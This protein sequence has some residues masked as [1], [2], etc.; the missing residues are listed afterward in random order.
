MAENITDDKA[1]KASIFI[2]KEAFR[3]ILTHVLRFGNDALKK[4]KEVMGVCLGTFRSTEGKIIIENAIP[5]MHGTVVSVGF[6]KNELDL[7]QQIGNQYKKLIVGWYISRP[8]WGLDFTEITIANHQYF[9]NEKFP[10]GVCLVFDHT[11]MG[12]GNEF[13]FEV[14]RLDD[15]T[16]KDRYSSVLYEI[17]VPSTLEYFKWIQK[18]MEDFQKK[19]PILIKEVNEIVE[20]IPG[21][22]QEI[23]IHEP[24]E[25]I[26]EEIE[27]YPELDSLISGFKQ[28]SENFSDVF[29]NTFQHQIGNWIRDLEQG[30]SRG[31]EYIVTA[32]DKM[33]QS[34]VGGLLKVNGWF[35]KTMNEKV[36]DFKN[37][38]SKY[39]DT[40][41]EDHQQVIEEFLEVKQNLM[42]NLNNLIENKLKNIES[43]LEELTNSSKPKL[44]ESSQITT[45]IEE[46]TKNLDEQITAINNQI[47]KFDQEIDDKIKTIMDP[48]QSNIDEKVEKLSEE[49]DPFKTNYTEIRILLDKLQKIIT[50]FRNLT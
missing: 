19:N 12:I 23:P 27:K 24:E 31:T 22:L 25:Q 3:N 34:V 30:N 14:F 28:G 13:G 8:G 47:K 20:T 5:V 50:D 26:E 10:Q 40:R 1:A 32:V 2:K 44:E 42:N 6:S 35:K 4:S 21:D 43:E 7:I 15:Y 17:E 16:K 49:L 29:I 18:F 39:V 9:Q 37:K 46:M 36:Y 45:K 48:L 38:V 41:I 11:L 33:R